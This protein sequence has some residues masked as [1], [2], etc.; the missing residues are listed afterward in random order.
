MANTWVHFQ[1]CGFYDYPLML[2]FEIEG[3]T[4]LLSRDF[5]ESQDEYESDYKIF[6]ISRDAFLNNQEPWAQLLQVTQAMIGEIAVAKIE[7]DP[8]RRKS[9]LLE[10][11]TDQVSLEPAK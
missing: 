1:Y 6:R 5:D 9:L 2:A 11:I 3:G 10:S 7:F 8:T 4:I